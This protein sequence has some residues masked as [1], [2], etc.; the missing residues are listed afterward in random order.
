M[1]RD[2]G[3]TE[4]YEINLLRTRCVYKSKKCR[5]RSTY[6]GFCLKVKVLSIQCMTVFGNFSLEANW[7][8]IDPL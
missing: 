7:Q 1:Y 8:Y 2:R 6:I 5:I 4:I 3:S